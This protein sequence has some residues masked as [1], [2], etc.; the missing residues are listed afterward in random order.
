VSVDRTTER[1]RAAVRIDQVADLITPMAIRVAA[2]LR[3]AEHIHNGVRTVEE[4]AV[5]TNTHQPSLAALVGHL[6]AVDVLAEDT[7]GALTLTRLGKQL[8]LAQ[9]FLDAEH[10]VGRAELSLVH[11]LHS[12]RTA[13]PA[14]PLMF[15][16]TF[17]EDLAQRPAMKASFDSMTDRHLDNELGPLLAWYDW[18]AVGHV[19]DLGAGN[20][21]LLVRLLSN[22]AHLRGTILDLPGSTAVAERNL[23]AAGYA[24]RST[25]LGGDFFQ[26]LTFLPR[27]TFVLSSV[28]HDWNDE[29]TR[30]ILRRCA[31]ALDPAE[32]LLVIDSFTD[33]GRADTHMDL[34]ML[35]L[36]GGRQRTLTGMT[37]LV[38]DA[39]LRV[40]G[41]RL[42]R[43]KW[44][45]ELRRPDA[46]G[47]GRLRAA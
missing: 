4:L 20:G 35:A 26:P 22:F 40:A 9:E 10:S 42:M 25:V 43:K 1:P 8:R 46:T 3:L 6:V 29:D 14:Y 34:R 15:G 17:W 19:V 18:A 7:A 5:R 23:A 36:F 11:L 33:D 45:L 28:L 16:S 21:E 30:A 47:A 31:E 39:G 44:L 41:S 13:R 27:A 2:A 12:V 37:G 32:S 38:R 24:Q